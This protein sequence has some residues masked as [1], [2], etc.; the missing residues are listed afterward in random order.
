MAFVITFKSALLNG[1]RGVI[2]G[3]FLAC[4][5]LPAYNSL[6]V[7]TFVLKAQ[8][9]KYAE[10]YLHKSE[11]PVIINDTEVLREYFK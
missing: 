4:N 9:E 7:K 8:A 2:T 6:E 3:Q 1:R 5:A 11:E 10:K